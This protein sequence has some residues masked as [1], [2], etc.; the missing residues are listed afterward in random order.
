MGLDSIQ[1]KE[2]VRVPPIKRRKIQVELDLLEEVTAKLY[3][4]LGSQDVMDLDG[5][6]QVA[7]WVCRLPFQT[8]SNSSPGIALLN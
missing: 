3:S 6:D 1:Q 4:L 8:L 5:L 7:E 2:T